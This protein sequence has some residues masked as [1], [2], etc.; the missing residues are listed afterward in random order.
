[1]I[2]KKRDGIGRILCSCSVLHCTVGIT[3]VSRSCY[4]DFQEDLHKAGEVQS[5]NIKPPLRKS[6]FICLS[7][8]KTEL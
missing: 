3:A 7:V 5:G 2:E 8:C 6:I 4:R 1:M